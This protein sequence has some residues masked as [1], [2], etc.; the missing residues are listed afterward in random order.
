M[1]YFARISA[2]P[3]VGSRVFPNSRVIVTHVCITVRSAVGV[4]SQRVTDSV[5]LQLGESSNLWLILFLL[6]PSQKL[7]VDE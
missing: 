3:L 7:P 6:Q 1:P 2:I 4:R 5:T